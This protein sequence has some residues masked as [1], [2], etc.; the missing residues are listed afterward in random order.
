[1][2]GIS[3]F[4]YYS[5]GTQVTASN[6]AKGHFVLKAVYDGGRAFTLNHY[7]ETFEGE[8]VEE[9]A[10]LAAAPEMEVI[11]AFSKESGNRL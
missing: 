6:P 10:L 5:T 4:I 8:P 2:Y 11:N 7:D 9:P 3:A 1:L